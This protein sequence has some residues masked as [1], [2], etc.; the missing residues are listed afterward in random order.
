MVVVEEDVHNLCVSYG[1]PA[2]DTEP[3]PAYAEEALDPD[4]Q[5]AFYE[6]H[7]VELLAELKKGGGVE[8]LKTR[9]AGCG[10]GL[11]N[12]GATCYMN[13]LLQALY[14]TPE[15]RLALYEW[16]YDAAV[17]G[18]AERSIPLQLQRL[19]TEMQLSQVSA[20][21]TRAFTGACGMSDTGTQHDVQELCRVLFDA[22]SQSSKPLA[23]KLDGLFSGRMEHYIRC[24]DDRFPTANII[25][26]GPAPESR[27]DE[28]YFDLQVQIQGCNSLEQ[29]LRQ[30]V[31][32]EMLDGDNQW[33]CEALNCKVDAKKGVSL[34][35]TPPILC[36]QLMRFIFD[37]QTMSRKKL[38]EQVAIPLVMDLEYLFEPGTV[39]HST[40]Y[41]LSALCLHSGTTHGGHYRAYVQDE[42]VGGVWF[43]ANDAVVRAMDQQ[44]F[45]RLFR[46]PPGTDDGLDEGLGCYNRIFTS[47][48]A[49]FLVYRRI[50]G[51]Q[52][53]SIPDDMVPEPGRT[54][55]L[56][57]NASLSSL[58][59]AYAVHK[60]LVE[61][62]VYSP[63]APYIALRKHCLQNL[64]GLVAPGEEEAKFEDPLPCVT[65]NVHTDRPVAYALHKAVA[66]FEEAAGACE[67]QQSAEWARGLRDLVPAGD[68]RLRRY[69][70]WTGELKEPLEGDAL[71]N[72]VAQI[73]SR[74][75][76]QLQGSLILETR[77]AG[78]E[79]TP[80]VEDSSR[81][82]VCQWDPSA[83]CLAVGP[84]SLQQLRVVSS[85]AAAEC[86]P[87]EAPPPE[88]EVTDQP[89][90]MPDPDGEDGMP[91]LF[92]SSTP[93]VLQ[94]KQRD[95]SPAL[96]DVRATVAASLGVDA[97]MLALVPLTGTSAGEPLQGDEARSMYQHGVYASD[98]L[99]AEVI[100]DGA[101]L[102]CVELYDRVKNTANY[103]FN[104][105][106]RPQY[107]EEFSISAS[108]NATL[109]ALK[110]GIAGVLGVDMGTIHLRRGPKAPQFKDESKTL[111]QAGIADCGSVFVGEGPPCSVDETILRVAIFLPSDKGPPKQQEIFLHAAKGG[112]SVKALRQS[113]VNP[114]LA[115]HGQQAQAGKEAPNFSAEGLT[116]ERIR[117]RDGQAG[118]NFSVLRGD[119]RT[120]RNALMCFSDMRQL[121]V[122]VLDHDEELTPDDI[123]LQMRTWVV[124]EGKLSPPSEEIVRKTQTLGE[125]RFALAARFGPALLFPAAAAPE[126]TDGEP[127]AEDAGSSVAEPAPEL[128]AGGGEEEEDHLQ[129]FTLPTVANSPTVITR[130][131][132]ARWEA[133]RINT[134]VGG[135]AEIPLSEFK[136]LR[137][138][139][140]L[141][142]RSARSAARGPPAT[143]AAGKGPGK[144]KAPNKAGPTLAEQVSAQA[145][146]MGKGRPTVSIASAP[147]RRERGIVIQ[148]ANPDAVQQEGDPATAEPEG[149][150]AAGTGEAPDLSEPGAEPSPR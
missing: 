73:V 99:C 107:T 85:R 83:G 1:G 62:K 115:W 77:T 46:L 124:H 147:A 123:F 32:P 87:G 16:Q 150:G 2:E 60:K 26:E 14:Y 140:T 63:A 113:L 38:N 128:V 76:G 78:L 56:N 71:G 103:H 121:A 11:L 129:M 69:D 9:P 93:T 19:F 24:A 130:L 57:R 66:A 61:L 20:I 89:E 29:A 65:I 126:A 10:V 72:P 58:Q 84:G 42:T 5:E 149:G 37:L 52:L 34:K 13:S 119:S 35:N 91:D 39:Q 144:G 145:K 64:S 33:F 136:E 27:R 54:E 120:L 106:D 3:A 146:K 127:E 50:D 68:A 142:L 36:L 94:N 114:L 90:P 141:I 70:Y 122:Q 59:R 74:F 8:R 25:S 100:V 137:D 118:K 22:L 21:S 138:G 105:P 92:A 43:E 28:V 40:T 132:A 104:H 49:Y 112:G 79:F 80:W 67:D 117:L 109:A 116:W 131:L 45:D 133:L 86:A 17:H 12:Q 51:A 44:Q 134:L 41:A 48:E 125:F 30:L 148:V 101:P 55:V 98:V 82:V 23:L 6:Q 18:A 53:P 95:T 75:T 111:R 81:V 96:G 31:E 97:A 139:V 47:S 135:D 143:P 88:P 15:F 108:K 7:R 4:A 102:S 110:E